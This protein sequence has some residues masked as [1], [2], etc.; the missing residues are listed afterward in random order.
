M[1]TKKILNKS[2]NLLLVSKISSHISGPHWM[3]WLSCHVP[4]NSAEG[5]PQDVAESSGNNK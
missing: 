1:L 5:K 3:E 4:P 2:S